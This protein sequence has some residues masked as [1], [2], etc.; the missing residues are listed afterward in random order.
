MSNSHTNPRRFW[1]RFISRVALALAALGLAAAVYA[2]LQGHIS[3][4]FFLGWAS[5]V[6]LM[7]GW[8]QF[9]MSLEMM[10][11]P[12]GLDGAKENRPFPLEF[13]RSPDSWGQVTVADTVSGERGCNFWFSEFGIGLQFSWPFEGNQ[14]WSSIYRGPRV[15]IARDELLAVFRDSLWTYRV[16]HRNAELRSPLW[17]PWWVGSRLQRL[18][19]E[20]VPGAATDVM[21]SPAAI[22]TKPPKVG[23]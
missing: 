20:R 11:E 2:G 7:A 18:F 6:A 22:P 10:T 13:E 12:F 17:V 9:G 21:P 8:F 4:M 14:L 5:A 23:R 16:D 15:F 19:P 3:L 1:W